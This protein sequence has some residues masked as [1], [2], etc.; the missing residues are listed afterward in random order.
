VSKELRGIGKETAVALFQVRLFGV[1][2]EKLRK[3]TKSPVYMIIY[4]FV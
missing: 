3:T 2:L 1:C 4:I